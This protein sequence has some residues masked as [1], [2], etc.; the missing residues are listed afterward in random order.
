MAIV[1]KKLLI[2]LEQNQGKGKLIDRNIFNSFLLF[3]IM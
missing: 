1:E 3:N 2:E